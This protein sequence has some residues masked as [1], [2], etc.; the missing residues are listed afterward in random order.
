MDL[1]TAKTQLKNTQAN[2]DFIREFK[3]EA[4]Q[5]EQLW[6]STTD[7]LLGKL[8]ERDYLIMNLNSEIKA[9]KSRI[10]QQDKAIEKLTSSDSLDRVMEEWSNEEHDG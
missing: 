3:T 7:S 4:I 10:T 9:L 2:V 8:K 1:D 6:I 5:N